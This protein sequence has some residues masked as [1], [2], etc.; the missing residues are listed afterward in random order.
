MTS[1]I[2]AGVRAELKK[3]ADKKTRESAKRFFKEEIKFYGVKSALV[4]KITGAFSQQAKNLDKKQIFA[5]CEELFASDYSEEAFIAAE[6]AFRLEKKYVPEDF[7]L[8]DR[9]IKKYINNWAKCDTFCNHTVGALIE[10]YPALLPELKKWA[11][12]DNRWVRRAAAVTLILPARRGKFLKEV[13][14][15]ADIL[16][17][18]QDD[19]VQKGYGWLL[20]EASRQHQQEVF[21]YLMKYKKIIPRTAFRYALEKMSPRLKNQ[22]MAK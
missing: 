13:F 1:P 16:L 10:K 4:K 21:A 22:A 14:E 2:V 5:L 3:Q 11:K 20:K 15:I 17:E 8:F 19:L 12:S 18:D 9:W 6:W 7:P